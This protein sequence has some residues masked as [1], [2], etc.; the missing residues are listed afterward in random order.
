MVAHDGLLYHESDNE[1][2]TLYVPDLPG[3]RHNILKSCHDSPFAGHMGRDRTLSLIRRWRTVKFGKWNRGFISKIFP[4]KIKFSEEQVVYVKN[5]SK[6]KQKLGF[7]KQSFYAPSI[8]MGTTAALPSPDMLAA[9][10]AP[11]GHDGWNANADGCV[12]PVSNA[13]TKPMRCATRTG[14]CTVW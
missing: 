14:V 8:T 13:R 7:T 9:N 5:E 1:P 4:R 12:R 3:M 10:R 2:R 6:E 11:R